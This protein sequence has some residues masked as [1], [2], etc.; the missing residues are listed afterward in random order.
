MG[1]GGALSSCVCLFV[2]SCPPLSVSVSLCLSFPVSVSLTLHNPN[3]SVT[4]GVQ[5]PSRMSARNTQSNN[6]RMI[7]MGSRSS[8][9]KYPQGQHTGA[10]E[11]FS[12]SLSAPHAPVPQ[13]TLSDVPKLSS[14]PPALAPVPRIFHA[15]PSSS[16]LC[17]PTVQRPNMAQ[18]IFRR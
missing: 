4:H 11:P 13:V 8:F 1:E 6:I 3:K 7:P 10:P 18:T 9:F 14:P 2:S 16:W 17:T 12:H 15:T 5:S